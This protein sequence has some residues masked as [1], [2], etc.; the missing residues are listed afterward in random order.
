MVRDFTN[1][2]EDNL[3]TDIQTAVKGKGK[4]VEKYVLILTRG[5]RNDNFLDNQITGLGL[6]L[7]LCNFIIWILTPVLMIAFY[8][9]L[10][11]LWDKL[12]NPKLLHTFI[13][14]GIVF[15]VLMIS[16]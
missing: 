16:W 4:H 10:Y 3:K 15:S 14:F 1:T 6:C 5:L 9:H 8:S 11:V 2:Y 13:I 7:W 12:R